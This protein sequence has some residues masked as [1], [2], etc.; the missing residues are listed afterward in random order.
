MSIPFAITVTPPIRTQGQ[1][2]FWL[3]CA[4]RTRILLNFMPEDNHNLENDQQ[5]NSVDTFL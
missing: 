4:K 2:A 5:R 3:K 1:R